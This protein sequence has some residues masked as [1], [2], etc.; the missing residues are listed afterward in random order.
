MIKLKV[1]L[2]TM[3]ARENST[4]SAYDLKRSDLR[5][6]ANHADSVKPSGAAPATHSNIES[7]G[8]NARYM[9]AKPAPTADKI[10]TAANNM[11]RG[12][13]SH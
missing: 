5:S 7:F 12:S 1:S 8:K 13:C 3:G 10:D 6:R 9:A 4:R 11:F 2:D